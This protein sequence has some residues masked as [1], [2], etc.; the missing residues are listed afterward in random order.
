LPTHCPSRLKELLDLANLDPNGETRSYLQTIARAFRAKRQK[1][2]APKTIEIILSHTLRI[3]TADGEVSAPTHDLLLALNQ[4]EPPSSIGLIRECPKCL[5]L[6]WA[7]RKDKEA[8]TRHADALRQKAKR[9]RVK[10]REAEREKRTAKRK[11]KRVK[12]SELSSTAWEVIQA[13][14]NQYRVFYRIDREVAFRMQGGRT[15]VPSSRIV[16]NC[17]NSLVKD[18]LL[19]YYPHE[20]EDEDEPRDPLE[21]RWAPTQHLTNRM[22]KLRRKS[23]EEFAKREAERAKRPATH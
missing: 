18:G 21:D 14:M 2:S 22:L 4:I 13:I 8:C 12:F 6:F 19:D 15:Q 9:H 3:S 1:Q 11:D 23:D 7:G 16:R 20:P 5:E 17:L 10:Q